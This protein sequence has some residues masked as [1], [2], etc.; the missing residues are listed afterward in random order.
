MAALFANVPVLDS[1]ARGSTTT[2]VERRIGDVLL[3]WES[4]ARLITQ[5]APRDYEIVIPSRT[6]VAEPPVAWVDQVVARR[7]TGSVARAYLEFL[8]SE[9]AQ[10]IVAQHHYRPRLA[11]AAPADLP[12]PAV[13]T[14][15]DLG[16]WAA[17]HAA[18]FADGGTFDQ[19]YAR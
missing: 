5:R 14:I 1:G 11:A 13:F 4:E 8:Y 2:F 15:D 18:H 19:I 12:R 17:A 10:R 7:G 16:G 9:E 3:A 6:I